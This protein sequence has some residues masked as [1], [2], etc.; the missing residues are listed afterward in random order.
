[1]VNFTYAGVFV[2][3]FEH[4]HILFDVKY[5]EMQD[6][7]LKKERKV[8]SLTD[9][10]LKCFSSQLQVPTLFLPPVYISPQI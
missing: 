2:V 9:C 10:K 6:L 5:V 8:I 7:H 3:N 1:M 4:I